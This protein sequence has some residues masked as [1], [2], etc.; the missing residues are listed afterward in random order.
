VPATGGRRSLRDKA[1]GLEL[2]RLEAIRKLRDGGKRPGEIA[3]EFGVSRAAVSIWRSKYQAGGEKALR[4][5]PRTGRPPRMDA[6]AIARLSRLV[7]RGATAYGFASD[8]W[9]AGRL[10]QVI[11]REFGVHYH[12]NHARRLLRALDVELPRR[13]R[14]PQIDPNA[15]ALLALLLRRGSIAYGFTSDRWTTGRVS[16]VIEREFRVRFSPNHV[17]RL[18]RAL[19]MRWQRAEGWTPNRN[20]SIDRA[21]VIERGSSATISPIFSGRTPTSSPVGPL[22]PPSVSG[23]TGAH[24]IG[25]FAP[26]SAT[27]TGRGSE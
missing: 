16:Q 7:R 5:T 24:P 15:R 21:W 8:V 17:G 23:R 2:R 13:G 12:G 25:K 20:E 22:P 3:R 1:D 11:E 10:S 19:G 4:R 14:P 18:L 6:Y 27:L 9:T 26:L